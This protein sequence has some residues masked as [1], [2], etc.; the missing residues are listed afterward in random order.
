MIFVIKV[1][2]LNTHFM[3]AVNFKGV[4]AS[5]RKYHVAQINTRNSMNHV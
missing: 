3:L 5:I 1:V 2:K 4:C